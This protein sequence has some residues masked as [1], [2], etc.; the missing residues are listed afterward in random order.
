VKSL[1]ESRLRGNENLLE[2]DPRAPGVVGAV[3]TVVPRDST[4]DRASLSDDVMLVFSLS[5][6]LVLSDFCESLE[7]SPATGSEK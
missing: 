7:D 4:L 5:A 6:S 2:V 3:D 1:R